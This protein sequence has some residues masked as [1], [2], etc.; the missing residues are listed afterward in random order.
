MSRI[1]YE[2]FEKVWMVHQPNGLLRTKVIDAIQRVYDQW[3]S[4][5]KKFKKISS[6][7]FH[8]YYGLALLDL[9]IN[10]LFEAER[11]RKAIGAY[12]NKRSQH[13]HELRKNITPVPKNGI[14]AASTEN[15]AIRV[16]P[17]ITLHYQALRPTGTLS[18]DDI[19]RIGKSTHCKGAEY[20]K[21]QEHK[22]RKQAL[23]VMNSMR[24]KNSGATP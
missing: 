7:R 21:K 20:T 11:Y 18:W 13:M 2:T 23:A 22:A 24:Q 6:S 14:D 10:D 16:V 3:I 8:S 12:F 1:D 5:K 9:G 15:V 17:E 4:D 19:Q